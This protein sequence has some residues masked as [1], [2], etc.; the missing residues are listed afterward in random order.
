MAIMLSSYFDQS[1]G[2]CLT[3]LWNWLQE[4]DLFTSESWLSESTPSWSTIFW[5]ILAAFMIVGT[6]ALWKRTFRSIQKIILF[7]NFLFMLYKKSTNLIQEIMSNAEKINYCPT[8]QK[9]NSM[10]VTLNLQE[11]ILQKLQ[12]VESKVKHLEDMILTHKSCKK[13]CIS[14]CCSCSCGHSPQFTSGFTST[15]ET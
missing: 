3:S 15:S 12:M 4:N 1:K 5:V 13:N 8:Y 7:I 2:F 6:Y 10:L 11:Q 9:K 14:P